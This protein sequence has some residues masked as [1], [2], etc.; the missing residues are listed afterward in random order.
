MTQRLQ[1]HDFLGLFDGPD[2]NTTTGA[3]TSSTVPQQSL[4]LMNNPWARE[5]A[6]AF[7][8]RLMAFSNDSVERINRAHLLTYGREVTAEEQQR[9]EAYI[10]RVDEELNTRELSPDQREFEAW[11]SYAQVMFRS[12]EL[13]YID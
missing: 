11:N 12:N 2:T 8:R 7:A 5:Q 3:R 13:L 1:Y 6:H 4:F 10:D 9:A